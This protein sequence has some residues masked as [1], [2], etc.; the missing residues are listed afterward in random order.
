MAQPIEAQPRHY[1]KLVVSGG[2]V[3]P[4]G[5]AWPFARFFIINSHHLP[6]LS[7]N[8]K[9]LPLTVRAIFQTVARVPVK[10]RRAWCAVF[11]PGR[12]YFPDFEAELARGAAKA[13]R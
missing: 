12:A 2:C 10:K 8:Q 7:Q 6:I 3:V 5:R 1:N 4:S 11:S 9:P 13:M